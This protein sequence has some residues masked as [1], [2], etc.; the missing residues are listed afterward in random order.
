MKR[1]AISLSLLFCLLASSVAQKMRDVRVGQKVYHVS[2]TTDERAVYKAEGVNAQNC[3]IV[4]SKQE[5]RL[6]VYEKV[7]RDTLLVA[8]YPVCYAKYADNK[9]KRG[10]M[11]TPESTMKKPFTISQIQDASG[12]KHDFHDGRGSVKAYGNWFMRLVTPPHTGIGIHG[13]TN[14]ESSIPGQDSEGCIRLRDADIIHLKSNYAR[15]GTKVVIKPIG[16]GKLPFELRAEQQL[17]SQYHSPQAGYTLLP[18]AQF[19]N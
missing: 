1:L 7:G 5:F 19:V 14:N 15:V 2:N 13:S 6:Y 3:F 17:G 4:I 9:K 18:G 16:Q 11:R 10:D 12:W 8:H